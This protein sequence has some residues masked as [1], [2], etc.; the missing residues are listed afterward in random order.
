[1]KTFYLLA[2]IAGTIIPY[3]FFYRF[4]GQNGLDLPLFVQQ[5]TA[6]PVA[7]MFTADL[8]ISTVAFWAFLFHEGRK[9]SMK[10]LWG[11]VVLSL[12]VGLS[13]AFPLFLYF[14]HDKTLAAVPA[15]NS[16]QTRT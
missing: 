7:T 2:A 1:M 12:T 13:L 5:A 6:N 8:V 15:S 11:Y 16:A 10:H 9:L 3:A 4:L 14:R